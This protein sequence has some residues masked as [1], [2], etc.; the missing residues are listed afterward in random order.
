ME[1]KEV[2]KLI[3]ELSDKESG[4]DNALN[5]FEFQ[6]SSAIYL[7]FEQYKEKKDFALM[8]E[9]LE[10]FTIIN[11]KINLYQVKG[12]NYNITPHQLTK[13]RSTTKEHES[14]IEK[15]YD[16]YLQ[17]KGAI[18]NSEVETNLII[19]ENREF[20]KLLWDAAETY[21]KEANSISFATFGE[22][23]KREIL[24][25]T[26]HS[27]YD[28]E[29]IKA[30]K[31]IPKT[32]HEEV[33]RMFIEDVITEKKGENKINSR[34]LYQ[35][36]IYEINKI[37]K[38]KS[39]ISSDFLDRS[40]SNYLTLDSDIR[41]EK[42][43]YLLDEQDRKNLKIKRSFEEFKICFNV[44]N[45]PI[46]N[47]FNLISS[48]YNDNFNDLYEYIHELETNFSCAELFNRLNRFELI[49]LSLLVI[50]KK[51]GIV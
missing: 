18:E 36:L 16:N 8:Y 51:E 14:I 5:G 10:D 21:D 17:V 47:E 43:N 32:R 40:L 15:M 49:A 39:S 6:V 25:D 1:I 35:A 45:H 34:A 4:G 38:N 44:S 31:L 48:L 9:K 42:I 30:R 22:G 23:C 37:R 24:Q 7:A 50:C 11:S 12:V 19:C 27:E 2:V 28:W 20:S 26:K 3:S 29:N 33:T 41:F 13:N 46:N